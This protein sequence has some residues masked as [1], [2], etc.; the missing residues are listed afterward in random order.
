MFKPRKR[1]LYTAGEDFDEKPEEEEVKPAQA[2]SIKLFTFEKIKEESE[3]KKLEEDFLFATEP[4]EEATKE[5][6]S[7]CI[8]KLSKSF[9]S[10]CLV[11]Q[12]PISQ[13]PFSTQKEDPMEIS[14]RFSSRDL[15]DSQNP[16]EFFMRFNPIQGDTNKQEDSNTPKKN[17]SFQIVEIRGPKTEEVS[18]VYKTEEDVQNSIGKNLPFTKSLIGEIFDLHETIDLRGNI[19]NG[20]KLIDGKQDFISLQLAKVHVPD[21]N[22]QVSDAIDGDLQ[23]S[24]NKRRPLLKL[25]NGELEKYLR[26][27]FEDDGS[28]DALADQ[29]VQMLA[30]PAQGNIIKRVPKQNAFNGDFEKIVEAITKPCSL[31]E[32]QISKK[33]HEENIPLIRQFDTTASG[34]NKSRKNEQASVGWNAQPTLPAAKTLDCTNNLYDRFNLE[35][36]RKPQAPSKNF[37]NDQYFSVFNVS[38]RNK[39]AL[40]FKEPSKTTGGDLKENQLKNLRQVFNATSNVDSYMNEFCRMNSKNSY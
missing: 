30:Q 13:P 21:V 15:L 25:T 27:V 16:K 34:S 3:C 23:L 5:V 9:E 28:Q 38:R 4:A 17:Q 2:H 22:V 20:E 33:N 1:K 26:S 14:F 35:L 12:P 19:F 37:S 6:Q 40:D 18:R 29:D 10:H 8:Y 7:S 11:S 31:P 32:A 39:I 24:Q 36:G